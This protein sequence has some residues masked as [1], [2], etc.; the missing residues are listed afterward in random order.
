MDKPLF[1]ATY[2]GDPEFHLAQVWKLSDN[3]NMEGLYL[4]HCSTDTPQKAIEIA[5]SLNAHAEAQVS[6]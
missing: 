5:A 2:E 6:A 4:Q 1:V 3:E